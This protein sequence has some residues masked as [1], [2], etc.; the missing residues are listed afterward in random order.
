M[1]PSIN[2][3]LRS[4]LIYVYSENILFVNNEIF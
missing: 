2:F 3:F 4:S 1:D